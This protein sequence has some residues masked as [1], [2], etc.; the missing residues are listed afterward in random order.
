MFI[1][2]DTRILQSELGAKGFLYP[3]RGGFSS[4]EQLEVERAPI[5]YSPD[6]DLVPITILDKDSSIYW[7]EK[8]VFDAASAIVERFPGIERL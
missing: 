7:I 1:P 5:V 3:S 6:Y 4:M 8:R 2:S